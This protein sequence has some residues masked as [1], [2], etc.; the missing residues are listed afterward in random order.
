MRLNHQYEVQN[1]C[2]F[3]ILGLLANKNQGPGS[4]QHRG[5]QC[6]RVA[7]DAYNRP[8]DGQSLVL[9]Q[10]CWKGQQEFQLWSNGTLMLTRHGMCV[11]PNATG[12]VSD[13]VKVGKLV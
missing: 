10:G 2:A 5:R 11:K 3:F 9:D 7:G 1:F 6:I 12:Q 13:G 8:K 4:L